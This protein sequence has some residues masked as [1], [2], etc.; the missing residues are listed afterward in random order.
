[1][2]FSLRIPQWIICTDAVRLIFREQS[3]PRAEPF[4]DFL[5]LAFQTYLMT[6]LHTCSMYTFVCSSTGGCHFPSKASSTFRRIPVFSYSQCPFGG[7]TPPLPKPYPLVRIHTSKGLCPMHDADGRVLSDHDDAIHGIPDRMMMHCRAAIPFAGSRH[8]S[9]S[10]EDTCLEGKAS[11]TPAQGPVD[12]DGA[13]SSPSITSVAGRKS[14]CR[15]SMFLGMNV[16][17]SS[18]AG[19]TIRMYRFSGFAKYN[20]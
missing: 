4:P 7:N 16:C 3:T 19:F 13:H 10:M 20:A 1:M 2:F 6:P 8:L 17:R 9:C 12:V 11:D 5:R 15:D 14:T 18:M